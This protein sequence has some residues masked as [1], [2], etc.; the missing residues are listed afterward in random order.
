MVGDTKSKQFCL[1]VYVTNGIILGVGG[2]YLAEVLHD[3][4]LVLGQLI[5]H[6]GQDNWQALPHRVVGEAPEIDTTSGDGKKG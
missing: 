1:F 2:Y 6:L 5:N 3:C 4:L